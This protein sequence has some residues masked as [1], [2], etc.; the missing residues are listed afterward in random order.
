MRGSRLSGRAGGSAE[1]AVHLRHHRP[2]QVGA[3]APEDGRRLAVPRRFADQLIRTQRMAR[4]G[5]HLVVGPLYHNGPLTAVRLLLAGV[6]LAIPAR[7]DAADTL[8][9]IAELGWNRR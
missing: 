2:A 9:V 3:V 1:P 8:R 5:M 6:P 4:Y 7:F